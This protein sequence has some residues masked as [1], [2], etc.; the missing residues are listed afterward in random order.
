MSDQKKEIVMTETLS[1]HS[2]SIEMIMSLIEEF[3]VN[4]W[5]I[6]P[7]EIDIPDPELTSIDLCTPCRSPKENIFKSDMKADENAKSKNPKKRE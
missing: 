7:M 3:G 6:K 1:P 2:R 4:E 5:D